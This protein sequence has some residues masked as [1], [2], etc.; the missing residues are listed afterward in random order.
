M[1]KKEGEFLA[2]YKSYIIGGMMA[3]SAI[4]FA[5]G[6][7]DYKTFTALV[8]LFGGTGVMALRKGIEK[9]EK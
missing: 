6:V 4:L 1:R 7:I 5:F 8:S 9:A 2:G 3:L